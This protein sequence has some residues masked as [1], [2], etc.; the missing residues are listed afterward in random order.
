MYYFFVESQYLMSIFKV[1]CSLTL[2]T[3]QVGF[4]RRVLPSNQKTKV[5]ILDFLN[6][7][8]FCFNFDL[9]DGSSAYRILLIVQYF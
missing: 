2:A 8:D 4:I 7:I 3:F 6:E 5:N 1:A 9:G